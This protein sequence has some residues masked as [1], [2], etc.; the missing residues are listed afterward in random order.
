MARKFRRPTLRAIV[1]LTLVGA[2]TIIAAGVTAALAAG[3]T[4]Q[5]RPTLPPD[6]QAVQDRIDKDAAA[7]RAYLAAHPPPPPHR[8]PAYD[9]HECCSPAPWAVF[10]PPGVSNNSQV[11]FP[12]QQYL[13]KNSWNDGHGTQVVAGRLLDSL[14]TGV[15][16][17]VITA[18]GQPWNLLSHTEYDV[19]GTGA[20]RVTGADGSVIH[21]TAE[22]GSAWNFDL[23]SRTFSRP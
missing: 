2:T 12:A 22:D 6:K 13:L 1:N 19:G 9:N 18:P 23:N 11:A 15:I 7:A 20:L 4:P 21:L 17:V 16:I 8:D 3:S 14:T 5:P 10:D